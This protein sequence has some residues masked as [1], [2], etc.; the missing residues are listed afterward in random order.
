[1]KKNGMILMGWCGFALACISM[2]GCTQPQVQ[3]VA[4]QAGMVA[5]VLWIGAD[6]PT[7]DQKLVAATIVYQVKKSSATISASNST[8][9]AVLSPVIDAYIAKNVVSN[10]VA[11]AKITE[12]W[13]LTSIDTM[14]AMN[15]SWMGNVSMVS[16]GVTSFC[17]GAQ[18]GLGLPADSPAIKAITQGSKARKVALKLK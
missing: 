15:T 18:V 17:D 14:F 5:S 16:I 1:M 11:I 6:N 8:Y 13:V 4:T 10:Q 9:Y 7:P 2:L 3:A 12:I